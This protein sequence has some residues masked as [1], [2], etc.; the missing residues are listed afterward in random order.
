MSELD[1]LDA[2]E[3]DTRK[4]ISLLDSHPELADQPMFISLRNDWVTALALATR[5]R[6]AEQER[7]VARVRLDVDAVR[8]ADEV[9]VLIQRNVIGSRCPAADALLDFREPPRSER[10]D[11]LVAAE[12]QLA[13]ARRD[14]L[15]EAAVV[16]MVKAEER[17]VARDWD[18]GRGAKICARLIEALASE[19]PAIVFAPVDAHE[20][21]S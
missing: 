17:C 20:E 1:L 11:R 21:E 19:Q 16:C 15:E 6:A 5:L 9:Q 10:G 3:E 4:A 13:S 8:L 2:F 12:A 18:A 14:T 7:D